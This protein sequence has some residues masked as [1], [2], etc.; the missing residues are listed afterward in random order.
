MTTGRAHEKDTLFLGAPAN[1]AAKTAAVGDEEGI[2]LAPAA[3]LIVGGSALAKSARGTIILGAAFIDEAVTRNPFDRIDRVADRLI[4]EA[5]NDP[6]FI[7]HRVTPPL[8]DI[9]F[10]DLTPSNS[11]RMSMASLFADIDGFTAFVDKAIQNGSET[12]KRSAT[13]I[14]VIREELNSVLKDDFGGKR[15]RFIGDCIQ[16]VLAEGSRQDDATAAVTETAICAAAMKRSFIL[17]QQILGGID[18]LDLAVGIEYGPVSLTRIGQRGEDSVRCAAGRA[19]VISERM[20]QEIDGGGVRLGPTAMS[21]ATAAV[22]RNFASASA[23]LDY[24]A[25]VDLLGSI[26]SPAV[27]IVRADPSARPYS[28]SA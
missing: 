23:I 6:E 8:S 9:K 26:E 4:A 10:A 12:I 21:H 15:V 22:K 19:I 5:R 3:Q 27:Q 18:E 24:D 17:C 7:F 13:N 28:E 25:A 16:G 14:H 11:V 20:Q 1:H 2:F